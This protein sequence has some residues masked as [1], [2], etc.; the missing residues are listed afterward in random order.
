MG[1]MEMSFL[2]NEYPIQ[3]P[4]RDV[5]RARSDSPFEDL[6]DIWQVHLKA[7]LVLVGLEIHIL[8]AARPPELLDR[9]K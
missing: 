5:L 3:Q 1:T 8:E 4:C 2:S 7:V 9:Y 6:A